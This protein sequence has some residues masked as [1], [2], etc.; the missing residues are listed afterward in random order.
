MLLVVFTNKS[1][2]VLTI[3]STFLAATSEELVFRGLIFPSSFKLFKD[4]KLVK[5]AIFSSLLF[6]AIHLLH[7]LKY[8]EHYIGIILQSF[9]AF[10]LGI[11][12][13]YILIKTSNIIVVSLLHFSVNLFLKNPERAN[14][15]LNYVDLNGVTY[16]LT[17]LAVTVSVIIFIG[18]FSIFKIRKINPVIHLNPT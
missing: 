14:D 4:S 2:L 6:G 18:L 3:V 8:P 10:S 9:A 15:P 5:S 11:L 17:G 7:L 12:L 13:C 16:D 1:F